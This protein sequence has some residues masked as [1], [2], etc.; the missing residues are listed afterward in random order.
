MERDVKSRSEVW[1]LTAGTAE[2]AQALWSQALE[3]AM[4][5][6]D[7]ANAVSKLLAE[8]KAAEA[9]RLAKFAA[10]N[11]ADQT[12][13]AEARRAQAESDKANAKLAPQEG[14][15]KPKSRL[16]RGNGIDDIPAFIYDRIASSEE[17]DDLLESILEGLKGHPA[18]SKRGHRALDAA[19]VI[20][21]RADKAAQASEN[22]QAVAA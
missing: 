8:H 1:Q 2:A 13:A 15:S 17:P 5:G 3:V 7:A 19:L 18:L 6:A 4:T 14:T 9:M 12:L 22:G 16:P 20:L 11:P 10:E 21:G